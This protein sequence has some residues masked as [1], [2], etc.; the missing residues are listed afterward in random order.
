MLIGAVS[1]YLLGLEL[2]YREMADVKRQTLQ[3]QAEN[4]R[5]KRQIVQQEANL[6]AAQAKINGVQ[7]ALDEIMPSQNTYVI[8]PNQSMLIADGRLSVGLIGT[9]TNESV[10]MNINGKRQ[11]ASTGDVVTIAI[12]PS[13]TCRLRVGSF[14]MFKATVTALCEAVQPQ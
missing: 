12:D 1:V 13:T 9:P 3:L 11:S 8:S 2:A 14:D 4:E 10:T 5:L 6:I 7:A